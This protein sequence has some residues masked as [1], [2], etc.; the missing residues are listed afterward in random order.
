MD[1]LLGADGS[2]P[3]LDFSTFKTCTLY[4]EEDKIDGTIEWVGQQ[5]SLV[6]K[7]PNSSTQWRRS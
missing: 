5:E 2:Y 3:D 4:S 1:P 6:L 7:N